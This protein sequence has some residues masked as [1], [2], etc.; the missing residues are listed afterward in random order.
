MDI[1]KGLIL[2]GGFGTR[3]KE[4]T[5]QLDLPKPMIPVQGKPVL[6]HLVIFLKKFGVEEVIF[7][8]HFKPDKI[9]DY[10]GDGSKFGITTHY[11]LEDE[12]LG[13]GGCLKHL[14]DLLPE[15]FVMTNGDELKD[16][17]LEAMWK[18]HKDNK[19]L[20][21]IALWTVEDPSAYGVARLEGNH[22]L[23][24]VEKPKKEEA[25]SNYIN[26]GLYIMEPEAIDLIPEGFAMVEKDLFPQVAKMGRLY[27]YPFTGQWFD[28][29]TEERYERAKKLW[30]GVL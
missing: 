6:E 11:F 28:T 16:F 26:S 12:A 1:K 8:L 15:T 24:F 9:K 23:E 17:D 21:T 29:G 25:P 10:F 22:I 7:A 18:V 3:L 13:T 2:A 14:K 30:R 19:A 27:G 4:L 20:V 5:E